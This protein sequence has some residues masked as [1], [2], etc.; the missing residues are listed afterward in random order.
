[1]KPLF[2]IGA[3]LAL[4]SMTAIPAWATCHDT[5]SVEMPDDAVQSESNADSDLGNEDGHVNAE[6]VAV[7]DLDEHQ[8]TEGSEDPAPEGYV[9]NV[10]ADKIQDDADVGETTP[11]DSMEQSEERMADNASAT[12]T[13]TAAMKTDVDGSGEY[14]EPSESEQQASMANAEE[15]TETV[16]ELTEETTPGEGGQVEAATGGAEPTENWFGCGPEGESTEGETC[17]E[18]E[19]DASPDGT[20]ESRDYATL[21]TDEA[22]REVN[23]EVD[24]EEDAL[25]ETSSES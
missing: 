21:E 15:A 24:C 5:S 4:L 16:A 12:D 17:E 22:S 6:A 3:G 7:E 11:A 23:L 8:A 14:T 9:T 18:A 2:R 25:P 1:M 20:E 19:T 10:P 13:E